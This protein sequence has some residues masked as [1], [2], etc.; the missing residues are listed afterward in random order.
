MKKFLG[1]TLAFMNLALF[2]ADNDLQTHTWK[3]LPVQHSSSN[4]NNKF[5][6]GDLIDSIELKENEYGSFE[7][8]KYQYQSV[9]CY[10]SSSRKSIISTD[11]GD[12]HIVFVD[13]NSFQG[14]SS[15][16]YSIVGYTYEKS[17]LRMKNP[18]CI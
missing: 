14:K 16:V 7:S 9:S 6:A 17:L 8:E 11:E 5:I 18:S 10:I 1:I 4:S 15:S 12:N 3:E 13:T 2:A